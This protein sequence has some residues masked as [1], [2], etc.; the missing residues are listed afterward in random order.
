MI[1]EFL[2]FVD[3]THITVLQ[4]TCWH[5]SRQT[6]IHTQPGTAAFPCSLTS[7]IS[8]VFIAVESDDTNNGRFLD[9]ELSLSISDTILHLQKYK[10]PLSDSLLS[11]PKGRQ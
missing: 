6:H 7:E 3:Y 5:W 2:D 8:A 9:E 4:K 11:F 10:G 1:T